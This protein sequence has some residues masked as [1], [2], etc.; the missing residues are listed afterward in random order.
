MRGARLH[1][2]HSRNRSIPAKTGGGSRRKPTSATSAAPF[3]T[4]DVKAVISL[5]QSVLV[6]VWVNSVVCS[7]TDSTR[8]F[9]RSVRLY[10]HAD[11][12]AASPLS[13]FASPVSLSESLASSPCKT[14]MKLENMAPGRC[15]VSHGC[16]CCSLGLRSESGGEKQ[17]KPLHCSM[18]AT[19]T[20]VAYAAGFGY[21]DCGGEQ[22]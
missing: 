14:E 10:D 18:S 12:E 15:L 11:E 13:G 6:T 3:F 22:G 4:S 5:V 17:R 20:L 21:D 7:L 1:T 8:P 16:S 19:E 2:L 9:A